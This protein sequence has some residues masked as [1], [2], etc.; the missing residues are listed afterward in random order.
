MAVDPPVRTTAECRKATVTRY[1][2]IH[3]PALGETVKY[4]APYRASYWMGTSGMRIRQSSKDFGI[5]IDSVERI[6]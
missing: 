6:G 5:R 4:T 2:L 3:E 1:L